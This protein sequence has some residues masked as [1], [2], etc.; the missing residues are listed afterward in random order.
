MVRQDLIPIIEE[1]TV[2]RTFAADEPLFVQTV[3]QKFFVILYFPSQFEADEFV[4]RFGD[5][6]K[7]YQ[8]VLR[9]L[10][11]LSMDENALEWRE[12]SSEELDNLDANQIREILNRAGL[13]LQE[14]QDWVGNFKNWL[15]DQGGEEIPAVPRGVFKILEVDNGKTVIQGDDIDR[16]FVPEPQEE[17]ET[18]QD[19]QPKPKQPQPESETSLQFVPGIGAV[20][21]YPGV[22]ELGPMSERVSA[23]LTRLGVETDLAVEGWLPAISAAGTDQAPSASWAAE[24]MAMSTSGSTLTVGMGA[25]IGMLSMLEKMPGNRDCGHGPRD[26]SANGLVKDQTSQ[27]IFSSA[28]RL[29]RRMDRNQAD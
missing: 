23:W 22:G 7:D 19:D 17:L 3:Q 18:E 28:A 27:G 14:D 6:E 12:A 29:R 24:E 20:A 11:D 26:W 10:K 9:L 25:I 16:K 5:E 1:E 13:D 2:E 8:E 4:S 21:E 15:K